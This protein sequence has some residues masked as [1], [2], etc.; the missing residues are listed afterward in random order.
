MVVW[1]KTEQIL[2][3]VGT[4]FVKRLNVCPLNVRNFQ[5]RR[6]EWPT[7]ELATPVVQFLDFTGHDAVAHKSLYQ[8][9]ALKHF[10]ALGEALSIEVPL[11]RKKKCR[12]PR[13]GSLRGR[14]LGCVGVRP[15]LV[16]AGRRD[17]VIVAASQ[18]A[19]DSPK[20]LLDQI[21]ARRLQGRYRIGHLGLAD[22]SHTV[23]ERKLE[24]DLGVVGHLSSVRPFRCR[25]VRHRLLPGSSPHAQRGPVID[26][27]CEHRWHHGRD[28]RC[29]HRPRRGTPPSNGRMAR[30]LSAGHECGEQ[31]AGDQKRAERDQGFPADASGGEERPGE[32]GGQQPRQ[33][34][35]QHD[36]APALRSEQ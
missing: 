19:P 31:S 29:R 22:S 23:I 20:R 8:L 7:P 36:R 4:S 9:P 16:E 3:L 11:K 32:G 12:L 33:R 35:A 15:R 13:C 14:E 17:L 1:A 34:R 25:P 24:I 28:T 27:A 21:A 30:R 2:L 6:G 5:L 18:R 10:S 26:P